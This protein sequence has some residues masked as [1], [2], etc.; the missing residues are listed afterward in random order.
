[1]E[2]ERGITI[3]HLG[4]AV[5]HVAY[6]EHRLHEVGMNDVI[7]VDM[8]KEEKK[9]PFRSEPVFEIKALPKFVEPYYDGFEKKK[10]TLKTVWRKGKK[11][12][13]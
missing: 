3:M 1:M 6:L 2:K 4:L 9:D 12:I 13:I 7:L 10:R 8:E 11:R 5:H